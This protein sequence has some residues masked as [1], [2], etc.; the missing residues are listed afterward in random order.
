VLGVGNFQR[1]QLVVVDRHVLTLPNVP[2]SI[3]HPEV[4][5]KRASKDAAE[6][7]GPSPFEARRCAPSASG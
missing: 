7:L 3:R 5:A 6:A 2:T 1:H 4:R